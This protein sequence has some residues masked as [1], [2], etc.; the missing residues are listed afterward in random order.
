MADIDFTTLMTPDEIAAVQRG[1]EIIRQHTT[2]AKLHSELDEAF[3]VGAGLLIGRTT[4]MKAVRRNDPRGRAYNEVFARWKKKYGYDLTGDLP[5]A[6]FNNC[7]VIAEQRELAEAIIAELEPRQR[8]GVGL[9]GLAER[10]RDRLKVT[11]RAERRAAPAARI[12]PRHQTKPGPSLELQREQHAAAHKSFAETT[13]T[14]DER[15]GLDPV[16]KVH[17]HAFKVKQMNDANAATQGLLGSIINVASPH[18]P[19]AERFME[20]INAM[21]AWTPDKARKGAGWDTDFAAKARK[22]LRALDKYL[23]PAAERLNALLALRTGSPS[24]PT[25]ASTDRDRRVQQAR[26]R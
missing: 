4:A 26:V 17:L 3:T 10:V 23:E 12:P 8:I 18:K 16:Q 21:Q 2:G 14:G 13:P 19:D 15:I 9:A 24:E 1:G 20:L 11:T 6:Y 22:T 25:P 5:K 7:I